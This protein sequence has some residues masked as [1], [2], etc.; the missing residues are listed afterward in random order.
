MWLIVKLHNV[1]CP[2]YV[3][4]QNPSDHRLV[5]YKG[6]TRWGLSESP[7]LWISKVD[8]PIE[9]EGKIHWNSPLNGTLY[10]V[11]SWRS[12]FNDQCTFALPI[13][14]MS[15]GTISVNEYMGLTATQ[16]SL[17]EKTVILQ[18]YSRG[19]S[20]GAEAPSRVRSV[21][22]VSWQPALYLQ[23]LPAAARISLS[24]PTEE[25][26]IIKS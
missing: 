21:L 5:C 3:F 23:I 12:L 13:L 16:W 4:Y 10:Y 1:L 11:L 9:K 17:C 22:W 8:T 19:G 15:I 7:K 26:G 14:D 2:S 18:H 25:G 24:Q 6:N 20:S